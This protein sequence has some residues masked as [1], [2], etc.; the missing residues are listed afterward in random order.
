M[1]SDTLDTTVD[2]SAKLV[3]MANQIAGFFD[4]Q[5]HADKVAETANHLREFWDPRMRDQLQD[6]LAKGGEGLSPLA[7]AAAKRLAEMA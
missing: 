3:R 7:L 4:T 5:P 6:H 1:S 2:T